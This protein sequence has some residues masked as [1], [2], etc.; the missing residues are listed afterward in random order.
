VF[1]LGEH[2]DRTVS[3]LERT[4]RDGG[5]SKV[6][7][8]G[9]PLIAGGASGASC[10]DPP[11][12]AELRGARV[13]AFVIHDGAYCR[14]SV[15]ELRRALGARLGVGLGVTGL[16]DAPA[17]ANRIAAGVFPVDPKAPDAR[18]VA[19][20]ERRHGA[21]SWWAALGR[22]AAMLAWRAVR[23][24]EESS[25]DPESVKARRVQAASALGAA[26]APL[27]TSNADGF[28]GNQALERAITLVRE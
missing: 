8:F 6:M 3:L 10:G 11:P 20:V 22:D 15:L 25:G 24:L 12:L 17:G 14:E 1:V 9:A 23:D 5:A 21:P 2:P 26:R 7:T 4:L 18:V 19:W 16:G 13:D 28:R 27:W